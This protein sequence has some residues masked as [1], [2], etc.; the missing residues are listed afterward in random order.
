MQTR[1]KDYREENARYVRSLSP[2]MQNF[3]NE[4][5]KVKPNIR[6]TSG[7]RP[8]KKGDDFSWHH[9]GDAIDFGKENHDVYHYL[10]ND[11]EG[12]QLMV[13]YGYGIIDE[14]NPQELIDTKAT[15]PIFHIGPDSGYKD[16][17]KKR[18]ENFGKNEEKVAFY[19][20]NPL[21]DYGPIINPGGSKTPDRSEN[22]LNNQQEYLHKFTDYWRDPE[23]ARSFVQDLYEGQKKEEV[24]EEKEEKVPERKELREA[25]EKKRRLEAARVEFA[26]MREREQQQR[27]L[28]ARN[29]QQRTAQRSKQPEVEKAPEIQVQRSMPQLQSLFTMPQQFSE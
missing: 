27:E 15:A 21:Y 7:Y 9:T 18:L 23:K 19:A 22:I 20:E 25:S 8:A 24:K 13:D 3:Y 28:Q 11:K 12:L 26:Q 10:M 17:P 5:I 1:E 14:T 4:L 29:R 6:L 2:K 16:I